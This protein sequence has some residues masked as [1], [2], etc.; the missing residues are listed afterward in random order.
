MTEHQ[1]ETIRR[2]RR[3]KLTDLMVAGLPKKRKRYILA[4]PEMGGLYVRVPSEG[5]NV[6]CAV[7]R[8]P[9]G[10]K[11][12]WATIGSSEILKVE[13][14]REKA[15]AAIKRIK[16]GLSPFEAL[17]VTPDSFES[18]AE[19]WF[20]RR[21]VKDKLRTA[22]EIER[23]L[24]KY[25]Y[26]K[27]GN[28]EFAGIKRSDVA[29][30]LDEIEDKNG[31][32]QADLVLA[33]LRSISNW[34]A[35]RDD[36]YTTPFVRGM[37]RSKAGARSRILDDA[38]LRLV[39]RQ[40]EANGSFGAVIRLLLLTA[41]RREKVATMK[42]A[43]LDGATWTIATAEREKGNAGTLLLPPR[44][45]EIINAQPRL[46]GN[47]YVFAGRRGDGGCLDISQ[48][49]RG[50][51]AKLP[52]AMPRWTLHD[53]RRTSRSLMSR[54]GIQNDVAEQVLG[55]AIPGVAGVYNRFDYPK[56]KADALRR[57][58]SLID[59]II[60]PPADNVRQ[61]RRRAAKS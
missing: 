12:V 48:S 25:V 61:L 57:L 22:G 34:F 44:A 46:S 13:E 47:P 29:S 38:E 31:P 45:I 30:L 7:A 4:D 21:V 10:G 54:A 41:Q 8:R 39:W 3:Q 52:A 35:K 32:R 50:F 9:K 56:E 59:T 26:P 58:A 40:A 1:S 20:K 51:D 19:N 33:I 6:F 49:K 17:P 28:R 60:S 27:W 53:L 2:R 16:A 42:W 15:R 5:A 36:N 14:A 24:K 43:D 18:V 11:Q 37:G 23:C 55:H